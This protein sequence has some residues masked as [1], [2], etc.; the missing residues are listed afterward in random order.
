MAFTGRIGTSDSKLGDI[1]LGIVDSFELA[2]IGFRAHVLGSKQVR[3]VFDL[4]VTDSALD[5]DVYTLAAVT[6]GAYTPAISSVSFYDADQVS[7][8]LELSDRLQYGS[9]YSVQVTG[10]STFGG[11]GILDTA[12]N[13]TANVADLPRAIAAYL[14]RAGT[15]DIVFD[16]AVGLYSG[17]AT[18]DLSGNAMVLL[19]WTTEGVPINV[20]RFQL[21][22]VIG[23]PAAAYT[24]NFADAIDV[25]DNNSSGSIPLSLQLRT[26]PPYDTTALGSIQIIDAWMTD[27]APYSHIANVRVFFNVPALEADVLNSA[28][29]QVTLGGVPVAFAALPS[30]PGSIS[31][32]ASPVGDFGVPGLLRY[33]ADLKVDCSS[34][35]AEFRIQATIS[36]DDG[37][38]VT[39]P[40]D[41]TGDITA[42]PA[43]VAAEVQ[44]SELI[45]DEGIRVLFDHELM[46]D[47]SQ[48]RVFL[49]DLPQTSTA[50]L[51]S[52]SDIG[53]LFGV[54]QP[55]DGGVV[56]D[57]NRILLTGQTA[58][59]NNGLWIAHAAAVWTRPADFA[60]GQNAQWRFVSVTGGTLY[61]NTRWR[62][63]DTLAIIGTDSIRVRLNDV[64]RQSSSIFA[65]LF[66]T[67][68]DVWWTYN[69]LVLAY[70]SHTGVSG[71]GHVIP[72]TIYI[73]SSAD[74]LVL[75]DLAN[76]LTVVNT[77]RT[78]YDGHV[79]G[80]SHVNPDVPLSVPEATDFQSL[81]VLVDA[82]R[83][84]FIQHN[85]SGHEPHPIH[86][87]VVP[88]ITG[89]HEWPG[90]P[91][92]TAGLWTG[93]EVQFSGMMDG[94]SHILSGVLTD[95]RY[96]LTFLRFVSQQFLLSVPFTGIAYIPYL[97]SALPFPALAMKEDR[98]GFVDRY[99]TNDRVEVYFSK[100]LYPASLTPGSF[101]VITGGTLVTL[102]LEWKDPK[103]AS[104]LV[105]GMEA[106]QYSVDVSGL[107]DTA[108]NAVPAVPPPP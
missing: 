16:R 30:P 37:F 70:D 22:A 101:V 68:G 24:V 91:L 35:S 72:E 26:T 31:D 90:L 61:S 88:V 9:N 94:G 63:N 19:D 27:A 98:A 93:I 5:P 100:P 11:Q 81:T 97:A 43:S 85:S 55:I 17:A 4:G 76:A 44:S 18:A 2:T 57:N 32:H 29:W 83:K 12:Q 28:N 39:N 103:T 102:G 7:V 54:G 65:T 71:A 108:G 105:T 47:L 107:T 48:L 40:S 46:N 25:A 52:R 60:E 8:V 41:T 15:I 84:A 34:I 49:P 50:V 79:Q 51:V 96:D 13:F 74:Y 67:Y 38:S 80:Q 92:M 77:F 73:V 3:V 20:I 36:S 66:T 62:C 23:V 64:Q 42:K 1:V 21:P 56:G 59:V 89:H 6:P 104:A 82:L 10:V 58:A 86:P 14:G 99:L 69:D 106:I 75:P 53:S 87:E 33:F 95:T 78:K 45:I